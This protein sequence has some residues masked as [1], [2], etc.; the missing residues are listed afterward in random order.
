[1]YWLHCTRQ[2]VCQ[3]RNQQKLFCF[4]LV[5]YLASSSTTEVEVLHSR[6]IS[7]DVYQTAWHHNPEEDCALLAPIFCDFIHHCTVDAVKKSTDV[8]V[9]NVWKVCVFTVKSCGDVMLYGF[10]GGCHVQG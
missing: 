2:R 3:G 10:V 4:L 1:M 7:V 5:S 6:E 8:A 9:R